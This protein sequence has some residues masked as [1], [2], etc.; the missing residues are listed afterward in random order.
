MQVGNEALGR[1]ILEAALENMKVRDRVL[2]W[3]SYQWSDVM[4]HVALGNR[5]EALQVFGQA[6]DSGLRYRS[7]MLKLWLADY[8]DDPEFQAVFQKLEADI[9]AQRKQ[10]IA[11]GLL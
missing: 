9:T 5:D 3:D 2:G 4:A 1:S 7:W 8:Q 6:V 11:E 10:A